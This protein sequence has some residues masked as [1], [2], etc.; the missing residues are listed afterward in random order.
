MNFFAQTYDEGE[1]ERGVDLL[2][3]SSQ[4]AFPPPPFPCKYLH[5]VFNDLGDV[6]Q[7]VFALHADGHD[8]QDIHI[9][10]CWDYVAAAE[11]KRQ[12]QG[13]LAKMLVRLLTFMDEGFGDIYLHEARRGNHILVVHLPSRD[14]IQRA[15]DLLLLHGARLIRYVDT[16][17][18]TYLSR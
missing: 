2:P 14:Q 17:K 12:Q 18:V 5:C 15:R 1:N 9:M 4:Q 13:K 3:V 7:A 6:V 8:S 10:S 16:W 11:R